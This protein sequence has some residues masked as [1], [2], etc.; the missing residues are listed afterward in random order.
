ME[1][2]CDSKGEAI[3]RLLLWNGF[4]CKV[5]NANI[6]RRFFLGEHKRSTQ[7]NQLYAGESYL[8]RRS[9]DIYAKKNGFAMVNLVDPELAG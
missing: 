9:Q 6:P 1:T 2:E 7:Q 3:K 5:E 8:R 4:M